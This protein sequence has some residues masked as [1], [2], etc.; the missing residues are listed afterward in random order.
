MAVRLRGTSWQAD[1]QV[2]G[3]RFRRDG[4]KTEAEAS[5]W[6]HEQRA[7]ILKGQEV[8]EPD[9]SHKGRTVQSLF[10]AVRD[11]HWSTK[12]A[13]ESLAANGRRVV[14]DLGPNTLV[15][16]IT[17]EKIDELVSTW[18]SRGNAGGTV[19]RKLAALSKMLHFARKRGWITEVPEI[20]R[21]SEY[22]GRL[23]WLTWEEERKVLGFLRYIGAHDVCD[24]AIFLIDTGSRLSEALSLR[25]IDT[26]PRKVTFCVTKSDEIRSVPLTKRVQGILERR[27]KTNPDGP[28]IGISKRTLRSV[29][30]R[31]R[32]HLK[33]DDVVLHT[34]RHTC[35]S[36][37]VQGGADLRRVQLWMGHKTIQI[38]L[39]YAHLAPDDLEV[40]LSIL[41]A[42]E[43]GT[44]LA[45]GRR[46]A[47][48][49]AALEQGAVAG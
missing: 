18:R 40:C 36:R 8:I 1:F 3:Q 5:A 37:L 14:E 26:M 7:R 33:M 47:T 12:K 10:E 34:L 4:F 2:G 48:E 41:E 44:P 25:W 15:R 35:C 20:E 29:W 43:Q 30:D 17:V 45:A 24:L 31:M 22:A 11:R 6:E 32:A 28:F 38:T 46:E 23:R 19:N 39:R 9:T 13:G 49:L 21:D 42:G 27:R 16:D